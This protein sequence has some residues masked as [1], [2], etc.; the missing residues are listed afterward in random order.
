MQNCS[1][2]GLGKALHTL[3]D[4]YAHSGVYAN[5]RVHW[6]TT[7]LFAL[8]GGDADTSAEANITL[9]DGATA[10]TASVLQSFKRKCLGGL[11]CD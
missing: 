4:A 3:Q 10:M 1:L 7:I 8:A 11:C 6:T 5:P 2:E 9:V